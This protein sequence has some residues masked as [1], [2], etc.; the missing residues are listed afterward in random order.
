MATPSDFQLTPAAQAA[1][2]R[3]QS[4]QQQAQ[5]R[6]AQGLARR[7]GR[8]LG[9]AA[10]DAARTFWGPGGSGRLTTA[11]E[12]ATRPGY[13]QA[14]VSAAPRPAVISAGA[15]PTTPTSPSSPAPAPKPPASSPPP[16]SSPAPAPAPANPPAQ[17]QFQGD[18]GKTG[19]M[20]FARPAPAPAPDP[21]K[22]GD[23]FFTTPA[24]TGAA[25][26]AQTPVSTPPDFEPQVQ[27]RAETAAIAPP[28]VNGFLG[29]QRR[30]GF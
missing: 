16:T 7:Q 24:D 1:Q 3:Q 19:D 6:F 18:P 10:A 17:Q 29:A 4:A 25:T 26:R 21:G 23:S 14:P 11:G 15:P 27:P 20:A 30:R 5:G 28:D 9:Q 8:G 22:T 12:P 2:A 13:Y